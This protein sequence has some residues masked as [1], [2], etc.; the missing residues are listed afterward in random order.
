[1]WCGERGRWCGH[2]RWSHAGCLSFRGFLLRDYTPARVSS[3]RDG[4]VGLGGGGLRGAGR[5]GVPVSAAE[6]RVWLP[7]CQ[8][9]GPGR[10]RDI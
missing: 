3:C 9:G 8:E 7:A 5:G 4:G 1:M 2:S 10:P 6:E